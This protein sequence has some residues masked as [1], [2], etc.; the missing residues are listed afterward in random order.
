MAAG[1]Q[2]RYF[3]GNSSFVS[4]F[5]VSHHSVGMVPVDKAPASS[6]SSSSSSS[7]SSSKPPVSAPPS[8]PT[9]P[10]LGAAS[11]GGDAADAGGD[12][13]GGSSVKFAAVRVTSNQYSGARWEIAPASSSSVS[14]SSADGREKEEENGASG[15]ASAGQNQQC[16]VSDSVN[17]SSSSSTSDQLQQAGNADPRPP[18]PPQTS[19]AAARVDASTAAQEQGTN[20]KEP[21][22]AAAD[23]GEGEATTAAA[24]VAGSKDSDSTTSSNSSVAAGTALGASSSGLSGQP[25]MG[26]VPLSLAS[27][28]GP[29]GVFRMYPTRT[30]KYKAGEPVL[31]SYGRRCVLLPERGCVEQR[32]C[33]RCDSPKCRPHSLSH[34]RQSKNIFLCCVY[35]MFCCRDNSHL[36]M[37]YG[38][39]LLDNEHET[40]T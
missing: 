34:A 32:C 37:E 1:G 12:S 10:A 21:R 31:F 20:L 16:D 19:D 26:P 18:S 8:L 17:E 9:E 33:R 38:F 4:N 23:D 29:L 13:G 24:A 3:A 36:S 30:T 35:F 22:E 6:P 5:I 25:L 14:P 28:A 39:T 11:D 15:G 7:S 27:R 2:N 40:V